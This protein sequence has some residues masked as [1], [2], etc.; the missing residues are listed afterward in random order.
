VQSEHMI[1]RWNGQHIAMVLKVSALS[2]P[3]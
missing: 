2:R 1:Y 3:R